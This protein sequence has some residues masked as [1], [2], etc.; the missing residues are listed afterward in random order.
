[1]KEYRN[2]DKLCTYLRDNRKEIVKGNYDTQ[3]VMGALALDSKGLVISRGSQ[4]LYQDPS[5]SE[6]ICN[7]SW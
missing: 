5:N 2:L 1:M 4:F 7:A 3:Y 6:E